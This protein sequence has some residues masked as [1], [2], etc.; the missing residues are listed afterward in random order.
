MFSLNL[1]SINDLK[2]MVKNSTVFSIAQSKTF[3]YGLMVSVPLII[4][5]ALTTIPRY[6]IDAGQPVKDDYAL[7]GTIGDT[8]GGLLGPPIAFIAALLTFAAFYVQ[9]EANQQQKS[10]IADQ[11]RNWLSERFENRFFELV[12]LHKENVNEMKLT[13]DLSGRGCFDAMYD[14][15]KDINGILLKEYEL[16]GIPKEYE[17][18]VKIEKVAYYILF[19]GFEPTRDTYINEFNQWEKKLF[20]SARP[21]LY[22]RMRNIEDF[23]EKG[24]SKMPKP[25][26]FNGYAFYKGHADILGHYYRHLYQTAKYVINNEELTYQ[27]KYDYLKTLRA[28]LSNFEQLMLYYN[29]ITMFPEEWYDL[30]TKYKFIK[31][32]RLDLAVLGQPPH[33]RYS[34]EMNQLWNT[35][36]EKMFENQPSITEFLPV[37]V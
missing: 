2:K 35:K 25:F 13:N 9:Y 19:Y 18:D 16:A 21:S 37:E 26:G 20:D 7:T 17:L 5:W 11:K 22:N 4:G 12:K 8:Y 3:R 34:E 27:E 24:E 10:D 28:Q 15:L 23:L 14:E 31:N 29:G 33:L 32:I 30:F 1:N 6:F 36:K